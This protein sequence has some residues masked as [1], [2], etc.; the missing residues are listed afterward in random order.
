MKHI[1]LDYRINFPPPSILFWLSNTV[2]SG[3]LHTRHQN[4]FILM[5]SICSLFC[6]CQVNISLVV[7]DT[8]ADECVRALHEAFFETKLQR[9]YTNGN[10]Y[11]A[12]SS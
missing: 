7:N 4:S 12:K 6:F 5:Y 8:E 9:D 2:S 10:G 11:V 1:I 3:I